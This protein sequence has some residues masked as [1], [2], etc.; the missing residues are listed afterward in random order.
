MS[1]DTPPSIPPRKQSGSDTAEKPAGGRTATDTGARTGTT[2]TTSG[3]APTATTPTGATSTGTTSK[4]SGAPARSAS[5]ASPSTKATPAA[6]AATTTQEPVRPAAAAPRTSTPAG[7]PR[8]DTDRKAS[9]SAGSRP[10]SGSLTSGSGPR[11]VRLAVSRV[12]PWSV[13]K[14]SFL[15]S[16]AIGIMIVVATA[17]VWLTLD[18]LHVFASLN[19]LV[20]E[21]LADSSIDLM[22]Y[23]EFD[24]VI[25]VATLVAVVDVFLITALATIGAFLYNITA[26]LVGGVHVTMT[27]E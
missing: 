24:R 11:R 10:A 18:G 20:T 25:S 6:A 13:M 17:V 14:L 9:P 5:T 1:S 27:D 7:S 4:G 16:V 19:D 8:D 2:T 21:I 23:V 26:A 12:D 15:I 3:K 22:R